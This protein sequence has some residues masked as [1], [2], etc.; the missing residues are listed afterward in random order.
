LLHSSSVTNP[1]APD[2][3]GS[4]QQ[5]SRGFREKQCREFP[6]P[7]DE[8]E[9]MARSENERLHLE[10]PL[11]ARTLQQPRTL[12][13]GRRAWRRTMTDVRPSRSHGWRTGG[14]TTDVRP[15]RVY[16]SLGVCGAG[17]WGAS[18]DPGGLAKDG[19][20]TQKPAANKRT[21]RQPHV[22]ILQ[23]LRPGTLSLSLSLSL[24]LSLSLYLSLSSLDIQPN[25]L[26]A[27]ATS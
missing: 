15:S 14:T 3:I 5:P 21:S 27:D 20:L 26:T 8:E 16:T 10:D 2:A 22:M 11:L 18:S 6:Q 7:G 1:V 17:L 23:A 4:W 19:Q 12:D 24:P 25:E 9:S 13:G